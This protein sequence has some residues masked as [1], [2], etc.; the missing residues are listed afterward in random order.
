M[1]L[2]PDLSE[3]KVHLIGIGYTAEPQ[4]Q[5]DDARRAKLVAIWQ[6]I[7]KASGGEPISDQQPVTGE[8]AIA[9]PPVSAVPIPPLDNIEIDCNTESVLYDNGAVGFQPDRAEFKDQAAAR[10]TLQQFAA[11]LVKHRSARVE[12]IG[13]VAHWGQDQGDAGL[14]RARA[15]RVADVLVKLGV[16]RS[17]ITARGD[18]W[19]PYPTKNAP[20]DPAHDQRN[21][22]VVLRITC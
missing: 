16:D 9:V 3:R 13:N 7:V 22:R 1:N 15:L 10:A 8:S 19:G 11:W 4:A 18:G 17:R 12:V 2:L 14:S 20:P 5:L 6:E 21:R